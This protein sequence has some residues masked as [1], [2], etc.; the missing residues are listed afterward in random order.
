MTSEVKEKLLIYLKLQYEFYHFVWDRLRKQH[1]RLR[2][3]KYQLM[4]QD[5]SDMNY[6]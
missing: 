6:A 4:Q 1:T 3:E 5:P 2:M